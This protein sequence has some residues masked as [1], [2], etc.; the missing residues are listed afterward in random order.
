[1]IY[2]VNYVFQQGWSWTASLQCGGGGWGLNDD[3]AHWGPCIWL[4]WLIYTHLFTLLAF[5]DDVITF[6][7]HQTVRLEREREREGEVTSLLQPSSSMMSLRANE[8]TRGGGALR[9]I[10]AK[11]PPP[12]ALMEPHMHTP[13]CHSSSRQYHIF[14]TLHCDKVGENRLHEARAGYKAVSV[15]ASACCKMPLGI[16]VFY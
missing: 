5:I 11:P 2:P 13:C 3:V 12:T 14:A 7:I 8:K 10:Q 4:H 9:R 15:T 16:F 1:M 6:I